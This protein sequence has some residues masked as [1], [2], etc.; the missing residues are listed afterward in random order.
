MN[1]KGITLIALV[2]TVIVLLILA[3]V[4][5][6]IGLGGDGLFEK[7]NSTVKKWN[8]KVEEED[9]TINEMWETFWENFENAD[10]TTLPAGTY[11]VGQEI[12]LGGENFFVIADDGNS[13]RLLAKYCLNKQGTMQQN[14]SNSVTGRMFS[15]SGY[16]TF[17]NSPYNLQSSSEITSARNDNGGYVDE[18]NGIKNAVLT[19]IDY[20]ATKGVTGRL[21]TKD[22]AE[23]LK[24][25]AQTALC[26]TWTGEDQTADGNLRFW[27]GEAGNTTMVWIVAGYGGGTIYSTSKDNAYGVRP[28]LIVPET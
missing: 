10:A 25:S 21:M 15:K 14:E 3:G 11:A 28:V 19:A 4:A 24:V 17:T 6:S 12:E 26:G 23:A 5:I 1:K 18:T 2:I 22:E 27:L 9:N 20:G 8:A 13:V 16:W 7:T